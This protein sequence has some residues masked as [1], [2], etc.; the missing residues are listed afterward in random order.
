MVY[1]SNISGNFDKSQFVVGSFHFSIRLLSPLEGRLPVEPQ[2]KVN[3]K[4]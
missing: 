2:L 1:T 3:L 4:C